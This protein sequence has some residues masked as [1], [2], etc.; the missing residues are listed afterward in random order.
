[1]SRYFGETKMIKAEK[2]V[3][4]YT[5]AAPYVLN[6]LNLEVGDGEYVSVVGDN[7]SGKST[8]IRLILCFIKPTGGSIETRAERIGYVPQ[9]SESNSGGFPITVLEML[10]NYR[11]LLKI[12]DKGVLAESMELAGLAG[13]A[14]ALMGDLSG[15]QSQKAM[16]ARALMG[17]PDLLLLD[18][19]ST[20]VD[21]GS[22]KDI[23]A[24]V[25][26]LN[27]EKGI[28]VVSVEHNLAAAIANST[29]IYHMSGGKGHICT[30]KQFAQEY[31]GL[32]ADGTGEA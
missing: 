16:I 19:P 9:K 18:E 5:G 29:L 31:T 1:M 25:K 7:G 14:D 15:G 32:S 3:F 30:P 11:R 20:G 4:S 17:H 13:K 12:K 21:A 10:D 26:K 6:G 24:L 28:T 8:L 23:Y 2:L 27:R 22:R